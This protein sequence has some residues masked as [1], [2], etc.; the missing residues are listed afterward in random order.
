M[1]STLPIVRLHDVRNSDI[2][3][4]PVGFAA[5]INPD[6]YS[7]TFIGNVD[8]GSKTND[9]SFLL[10][11]KYESPIPRFYG[12]IRGLQID[13]K[14]IDMR[15][16]VRI[17]K[18]KEGYEAYGPADVHV[19]CE[20]GC[21]S[22]SCS[23]GG[24]CSVA[25]TNTDPSATK[26]TCDCTRTSYAGATCSLDEGVRIER[27]GYIEYDISKQMSVIYVDRNPKIPQIMK[28]AFSAPKSD[29]PL[30]DKDM[31][32]SVTF[33]ENRKLE[34]EINPNRTINVAITYE[35][36][37]TEVLNFVGDFLDGFRHFVVV[38]TNQASATAVM[39]S[40]EVV[41]RTS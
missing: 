8:L 16:K 13:R 29:I 34:I 28:F 37:K 27:N 36:G 19:G 41:G 22:I 23:N 10:A 40:F 31:I 15:E 30:D 6:P 17:L 25:W 7:F 4:L 2:V 21:S 33:K 9:G 5:P 38:Q 3:R 14:M 1:L 39:V 35:H 20:V 11:P 12:C 26:T 24:H 18:T 32:A